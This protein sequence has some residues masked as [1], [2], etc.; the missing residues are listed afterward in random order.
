[1]DREFIERTVK[2]GDQV[3]Q[4]D[5]LTLGDLLPGQNAGAVCAELAEMF[6]HMRQFVDVGVDQVIRVELR[7]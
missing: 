3:V 2:P 1:M 5:F 4:F 7:I 6:E